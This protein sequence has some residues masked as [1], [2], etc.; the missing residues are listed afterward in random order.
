MTA[1]DGPVPVHRPRPVQ[2]VPVGDHRADALGEHRA[3]TQILIIQ[4]PPDL[5]QPGFGEC[6]VV[7]PDPGIQQRD[8]FQAEQIGQ[9]VLIDHGN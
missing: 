6:A 5:G 7:I 8:A 1:A 9:R 4:Q 3:V 2:Y